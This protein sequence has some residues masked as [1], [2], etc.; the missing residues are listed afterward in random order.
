M[1]YFRIPPVMLIQR[2]WVRRIAIIT[3]FPAEV[4]RAVSY[5]YREAAK[6]WKAPSSI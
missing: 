6:C 5:L 2:R 3:I 4:F 1:S